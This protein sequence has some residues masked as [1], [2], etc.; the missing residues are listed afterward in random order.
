MTYDR[1][2]RSTPPAAALGPPGGASHVPVVPPP[3][4]ERSDLAAVRQA[5]PQFVGRAEDL[6]HMRRELSAPVA[7]G[8]AFIVSIAGVGAVGA[9]GAAAEPTGGAAVDPVAALTDAL[10]RDVNAAGAAGRSVVLVLDTYEGI[11][12]V[13]GPWL[14]DTLLGGHLTPITGDLRLIISG[15]EPLQRTDPRWMRDWD[16]TDRAI[17]NVDLEPFSVAET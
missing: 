4:A 14:L 13:A 9:A 8:G 7:L 17:I 11:R 1:N 15:R 10:I 2:G 16:T 12:H 5:V 6:E 3:A